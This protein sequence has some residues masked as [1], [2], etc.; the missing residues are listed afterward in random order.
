MK[1][2]DDWRNWWKFWSIRL[3]AVYSAVFAYLWAF[4]EVAIQA[5]GMLPDE[6]KF[7]PPQMAPVIGLVMFFLISAPRMIKQKKLDCDKE[8]NPEE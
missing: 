5:Y 4:P 3:A 1:L 8:D 7:V 2:I 6:F